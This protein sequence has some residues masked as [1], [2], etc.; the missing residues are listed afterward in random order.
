MNNNNNM[1]TNSTPNSVNNTVPTPPSAPTTPVQTPSPLNTPVAPTP[2]N[3]IP[4]IEVPTGNEEITVVNTEKKKTSNVV[5]IIIVLLLV[6]FVM[7][8]DTVIEYYNNYTSTGSLT[9]PKNNNTDNLIGGYILIGDNTSRVVLDKIIFYN[10]KRKEDDMTIIYNY[11]SSAKYDN[12]SNLKIYVELY[13]ANKEII[14]RELFDIEGGIEKDTVRIASLNVSSDVFQDAYYALARKYTDSELNKTQTLTCKYK[15]NV[16]DS[17]LNYNI[18]FT[19]KNNG[20]TKYVVNKQILNYN[21]SLKEYKSLKSEY[22]LVQKSLNAVF[23]SGNLNYTVDLESDLN[24]FNPLY[25]KDT[26]I[27]IV[28]NKETLKEWVCE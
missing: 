4:P 21:E 9:P 12:P 13:N 10:F 22:S 7:N 19:F 28:K 26:L 3:N 1:N 23:Q 25:S 17:T 24:G 2:V 5:L 15:K 16:D 14:Y 11:E 20:L 27:T 8:I 18:L 6:L